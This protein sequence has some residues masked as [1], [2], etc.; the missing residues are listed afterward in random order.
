MKKIIVIFIVIL[1]LVAFGWKI[2]EKVFTNQKGNF[3]KRRAFAVPVEVAP[4]RKITMRD[5]GS[6]TG[7]IF[8]RSQFVVAPKIAGRLEKLLVN[9]GDFVK[10]N[11]LIAVLDDD[12]YVQRVDQARAEMEVAKANL[13][14]SHSGL[15]IARREFDRAKT[16]RKKKIAS[17]SELDS[18]KAQFQTQTAK[19]KVALAQVVQKKAALKAAQV[20]L[21]YTKIHAYWENHDESRVIGER[22]VD[23][24]AMLA[25][26]TP[27]V[28]VLDIGSLTAVIH[29]IERDYSKVRMGQQA[30]VS[31]DAYPNK[32]FTGKIIRI[33]PLLKETSRQARVEIEVLNP[34]SLLKPGMFVRTQI[35]FARHDDV[36]VV[37]L[38]ALTKRGG[39]QGV[40]LVD[41]QDMKAHFVPVSLGIIN[42]E[43]AEVVSPLISGSV[44]T[45]G[46]HL[47]VDG[48][49]V[50]LPDEKPRRSSTDKAGNIESGEKSRPSQGKKP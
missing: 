41:I 2:Y 36:A 13:E 21:S 11:Q 32:T 44:V 34:E 24:G 8:P 9:I 38:T 45:L 16:L 15:D 49:S 40:F 3:N 7:T 28:S 1:I 31:T 20:Y 14:E 10:R 19:H 27:I 48:S 17:E 47:I 50:I 6:F 29:V 4:V 26:N 35:E 30:V 23:E 43:V 42:G 46:H 37:P 5:V 33:S 22:F 39:Q 18:A 12:E 25:P